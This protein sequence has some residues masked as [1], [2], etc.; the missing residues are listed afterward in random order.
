VLLNTPFLQL[1]AIRREYRERGLFTYPKEFTYLVRVNFPTAGAAAA[2]EIARDRVLIDSDSDF[3]WTRTSWYV[4]DAPF[5]PPQ[6]MPANSQAAN[7]SSTVSATFEIGLKDMR[8]GRQYHGD[9]FIEPTVF[10]GWIGVDAPGS[11]LEQENGPIVSGVAG[12][13]TGVGHVPHPFLEPVILKASTLFE[14]SLRNRSAGPS[15]FSTHVFGLHGAR[16]YSL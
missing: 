12:N 14:I 5:N 16:L 2:G 4:Q 11:V 13:D 9:P 15:V 6:S 8:S 7:W 3:V 10:S 1:Q